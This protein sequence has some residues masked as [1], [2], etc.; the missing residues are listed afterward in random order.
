MSRP[1]LKEWVIAMACF[2]G[3]IIVIWTLV[4]VFG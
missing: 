4:A 3:F 1:D 2:F